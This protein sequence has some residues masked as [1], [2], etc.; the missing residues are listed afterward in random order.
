VDILGC[1]AEAGRVDLRAALGLLAGR[2]LTRLL[3]EGGPSV[4]AAFVAGDLV[5]EAAIVR[6]AGHLG[7]DA[8]DALL[9]LPLSALMERLRLRGT[10]AVGQDRI[11]FYER[12]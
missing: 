11:A 1:P 5:D 8:I 12:S 2:G 6:G 7:G 4:A 3:V 9:G 10:R